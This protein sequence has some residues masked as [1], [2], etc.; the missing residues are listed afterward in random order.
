MAQVRTSKFGYRD[1]Y[2][3]AAIARYTAEGRK[4]SLVDSGIIGTPTCKLL[5]INGMEDSI[6]PIEDT[7]IVAIEGDKKDLV[8]RGNRGHMGN[9]GAEEILIR[10]IDDALA[11]KP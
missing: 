6:F 3:D 1:A 9:L 4:F 2:Y 11:G 7:L 8:A 5:V 10:W